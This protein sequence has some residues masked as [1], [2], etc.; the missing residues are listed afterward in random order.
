MTAAQAPNH[1][2]FGAVPR[3]QHHLIMVAPQSHKPASRLELD[4][5]VKDAARIRSA[6]NIVP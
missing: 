3:F 5:A 6:V 1:F 2:F 4:Q